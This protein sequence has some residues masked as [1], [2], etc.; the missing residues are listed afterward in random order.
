VAT[1]QATTTTTVERP[2]MVLVTPCEQVVFFCDDFVITAAVKK[3]L[4]DPGKIQTILISGGFARFPRRFW[5]VCR[6]GSLRQ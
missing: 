4:R 5:A 1:T 2:G 3:K 6:N